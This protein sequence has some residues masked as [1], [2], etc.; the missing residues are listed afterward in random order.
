MSRLKK[1]LQLF[2]N[3]IFIAAIVSCGKSAVSFENETTINN[4]STASNMV[5]AI[6]QRQI[7]SVELL[8]LHLDRIQRYN[9]EI[10]AVVALNVDAARKRAEEADKAIAEGKDWG[11]LH[12]LPMTVKD[13]FEV[14]GM[15][16]TS[17][18]PKLKNYIPNRNAIAVQ[19]LIDAGAIIFGKTNVPYHA[20]DFQ[21]YNTIYGTTNNPWDLSRTPG[22]SSG[23]AAAAL[24]AGFT[25]LELGSD[26]AV[27]IRLP[28][29]YTGVF[30]H[31]T[32][33]GII[34]RY[35]HIPPMPG[36]VPEEAMPGLPL[37]VLGPLSRSAEDL[38]LAL[39]VLT[40]PGS[41]GAFDIRDDLLPPRR[42]QFKDYRVAVWF[43]DS[44]PTSEIDSEVFSTL[45]KAV[46]RL[47]N[48][49]LD[50]DEKARPGIGLD[51]MDYVFSIIFQF[52]M[53]GQL[54]LPE[55]IIFEQDKIFA[56]WDSFFKNYDVLLAPVSP[57]VATPHDHKGTVMTRTM[58]I[59][60]ED[61][62]VLNN[63][64]WNRIA[65]VSRLPA[66]VA[67]VG[68]GNSGLPIGVQIIGAKFED[69]T[70]IDFAKGLSALLGGFKAPP[71]YAE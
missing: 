29:H 57:T 17:G 48:A 53:Q 16:A 24:A 19:R 56:A 40:A 54:P 59:N 27:S 22:G 37:G 18:D 32:T 4:F 52:Y 44:F 66:T 58:K 13:V 64:T 21:S 68:F 41:K 12:G 7:T 71:N 11:P 28:A 62:P 45:Q 34:P 33:F 15:P 63:R 30:G 6:K 31:K 69:R 20:L 35:G 5:M 36:T 60:G 23:G 8:N 25:P 42:K 70:T 10:N 61:K 14:A 38:E 67:P 50:I 46:D 2:V 39:N 1:T 26:V 3:V 55:W 49:G 43:T 51:Q 9:D 65:V 47:R